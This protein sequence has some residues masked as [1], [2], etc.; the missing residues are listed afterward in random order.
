MNLKLYN[1]LSSKKETF[2]PL[3]NKKVKTYGCGPTVYN[4]PHIGNFRTFVFY[5]LLNRVLKMNG[6]NTVTAVNITD[7]D[8]K[9]IDRV[10]QENSSFPV[11]I[12]AERVAI[13]TASSQSPGTSIST[14]AIVYSDHEN[15]HNS[16][17]APCGMCRQAIREQTLIQKSPIKLIL[18][19]LHG[20]TMV[21]SD[22]DD[23]LPLSFTLK[24]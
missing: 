24:N 7:I 14:I 12:C 21:I 23:L 1:S 8:D 6:Y 10:N 17:L 20:Q 13:S 2:K 11:G 15:N 9:I 3:S 22:A 18:T 5:D 4:D 16:P 19:T